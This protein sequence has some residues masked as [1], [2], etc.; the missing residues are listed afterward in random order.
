MVVRCSHHFQHVDR[1]VAGVRPQEN[2]VQSLG[3]VELVS[4]V[5]VDLRNCG[6]GIRHNAT[7]E[8]GGVLRPLLEHSS[9]WN[10][11]DV[12]AIRQVARDAAHI[13]DAHHTV[14]PDIVL[15]LQAE[16]M[17]GRYLAARIGGERTGGPQ[18]YAR[19]L[20]PDRIQVAPVKCRNDIEGGPAYTG[21]SNRV[22]GDAVIEEPVTAAND[23]LPFS[24][25]I[26]GETEARPK[27][28]PLIFDAAPE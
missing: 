13:P 27:Q 8:L 26:V 7:G 19:P 28:D 6:I 23:C 1:A 21:E 22:T 2:R 14:K 5:L 15:D 20:R 3:A 16:V 11:V 25:N 12:A 24:E 18:R 17:R 9:E 10:V 4:L